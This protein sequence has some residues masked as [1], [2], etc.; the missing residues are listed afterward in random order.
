MNLLEFLEQKGSVGEKYVNLL[1]FHT[2]FVNRSKLATLQFAN[3]INFL[4]ESGF[5]LTDGPENDITVKIAP[6]GIDFL[7]YVRGQ[8]PYYRSKPF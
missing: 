7:S 1:P 8:Y 4:K 6:Y 5:V 3:Y 2:E